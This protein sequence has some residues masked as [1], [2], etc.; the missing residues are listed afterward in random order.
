M[1]Y[2]C[3]KCKQKFDYEDVFFNLDC[4]PICPECG[5]IKLEVDSVENYTVEVSKNTSNGWI[6]IQIFHNDES[7]YLLGKT[8]KVLGVD[9]EMV[10]DDRLYDDVDQFEWETILPEQ[11]FMT[12]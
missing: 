12:V 7:G 5:D 2:F 11:V 6:M 1:M 9:G 8:I 4:E 3:W 10:E